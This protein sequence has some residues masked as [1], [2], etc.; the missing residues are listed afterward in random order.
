[1]P[2]GSGPLGPWGVS[3][4]GLKV[5]SS[6]LARRGRKFTATT[7]NRGWLILCVCVCV[8]VCVCERER[9]RERGREGGRR[10]EGICS[11]LI[12]K[13]RIS[14]EKHLH[15]LWQRI[16]IFTKELVSFH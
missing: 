11:K 8:C 15:F 16:N 7:T 4:V 13:I 5:R 14:Q 3:P 10:E 9:E 1:M 6:D 12:A 2:P